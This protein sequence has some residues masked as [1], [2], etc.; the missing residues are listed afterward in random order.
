MGMLSPVGNSVESSWQAIQAGRSGIGMIDR[1]DASA[2]NTRIGGAI[3]DLDMEPYL[4]PKD[5]RK[6]DAFIHY[7]LIAAQQAVDD[8][9]LESF[10]RLVVCI[11]NVEAIDHI[12]CQ[13]SSWTASASV[14]PLALAS[15]ASS[16]SRKAFL[17]WTSPVL[18]R[19]LRFSCRPPL[20]T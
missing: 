9:G 11:D 1:F 13:I 20:S 8:S 2:Y 4:S 6:L 10:D 19:F 5:A 7:G 18:E 3:R 15:V 14:L 16:T 17:P 12:T